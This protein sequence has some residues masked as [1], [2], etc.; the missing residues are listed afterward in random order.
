MRTPGN[1]PGGA[2][3]FSRGFTFSDLIEASSRTD[4]GLPENQHRVYVIYILSDA[5]FTLIIRG[6]TEAPNWY[7]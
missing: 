5:D 2:I 4:G 3:S 6:F 1:V 7:E